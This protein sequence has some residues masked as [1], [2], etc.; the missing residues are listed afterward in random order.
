[1]IYQLSYSTIVLDKVINSNATAK[2]I[3]GENT[4]RFQTQALPISYC[5]IACKE[6]YLSNKL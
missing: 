3:Y 2:N 6:M 4:N 1:M 5:R